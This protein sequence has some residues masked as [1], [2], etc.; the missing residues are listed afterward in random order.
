LAGC[1]ILTPRKNLDFFLRK[2]LEV[3][4]FSWPS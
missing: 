2:I 4:F 3:F 1:I